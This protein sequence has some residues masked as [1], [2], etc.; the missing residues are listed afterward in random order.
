MRSTDH[1]TVLS[2]TG[3]A[4]LLPDMFSGGAYDERHGL[5]SPSVLEVIGNIGNHN[6]SFE[7]ECPLQKQSILIVQ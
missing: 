1:G 5:I 3:K 6:S 2:V 7:K 4:G